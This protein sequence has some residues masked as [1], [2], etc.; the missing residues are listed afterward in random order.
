[1]RLAEEVKHVIAGAAQPLPFRPN[2]VPI[3]NSAGYRNVIDADE[4]FAVFIESCRV[5]LQSIAAVPNRSPARKIEDET[6]K[7]ADDFIGSHEAIGER[8]TF[9]RTSRVRREY[10]SVTRVKHGDRRVS[11][12]KNPSFAG[13]DLGDAAEIDNEFSHFHGCDH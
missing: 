6:V 10:A 11:H 4:D 9:V 13:R 7:R 5:R 8:T 2:I 12:L 3:E 1:M